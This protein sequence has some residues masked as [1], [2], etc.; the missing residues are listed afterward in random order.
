MGGIVR[1]STTH[2]QMLTFPGGLHGFKPYLFTWNVSVEGD[3]QK[4]L[5]FIFVEILNIKSGWCFS[6][7][8]ALACM[9]K[10]L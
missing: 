6:M 10:G 7:A 2:I 5:K 1:E 8:R 3:K 4:F 9:P